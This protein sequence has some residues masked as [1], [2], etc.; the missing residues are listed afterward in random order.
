M[1][2]VR[3]HAMCEDYRA[4]LGVDRAADDAER[5]AGRQIMCP[6][7]VLWGIRDDLADLYTTTCLASGGREPPSCLATGSTALTRS[8]KK[9]HRNWLTRC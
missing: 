9:L 7:L 1:S 2:R 3:G 6:V 5:N 8:P 4:G